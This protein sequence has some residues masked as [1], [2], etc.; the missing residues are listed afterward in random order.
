[1]TSECYLI[2]N[3]FIKQGIRKAAVPNITFPK[4]A[5]GEISVKK[6]KISTYLIYNVISF[7]KMT[8]KTKFFS[9]EITWIWTYSEISRKS[10]LLRKSATIL[11]DV[12]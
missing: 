1:M 7:S 6:E 10:K 4:L 2:I 8:G 3:P 5:D 9:G 11:N 12:K